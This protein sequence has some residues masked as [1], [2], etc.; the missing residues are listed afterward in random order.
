MSVLGPS[1]ND[2]HPI[3]NPS[4]KVL[5]QTNAC[6]VDWFFGSNEIRNQECRASGQVSIDGASLEYSLHILARLVSQETVGEARTS[7]YMVDFDG[8]RL[9]PIYGAGDM[10]QSYVAQVDGF[11]IGE[12]PLVC[13][14]AIPTGRS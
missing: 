6:I 12:H 2:R 13:R 5:R 8:D 4:V 9:S 7:F 10:P 1:R 3:E 11:L 14:L